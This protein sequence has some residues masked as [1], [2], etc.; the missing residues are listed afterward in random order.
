MQKHPLLC[1]GPGC[2]LCWLAENVGAY[3]QL[4]GLPITAPVNVNPEPV[5][6]PAHDIQPK[7]EIKIVRPPCS[8]LGDDT[9]RR[10]TC[11]TCKGNVQLKLFTC[12]VHGNCTRENAVQGITCCKNCPDYSSQADEGHDSAPEQP[13]TPET[14][15]RLEMLRLSQERED[16]PAH[17]EG[18]GIV[19]CAGGDKFFACAWAQISMLRWLGCNLP[20]E[21]FHLGIAEMDPRMKELL[22]GL[23]GVKVVDALGI[24]ASLPQKPRIL[25]GWELKPFSITHSSFAEVLFLD[26]DCYPGRDP[27]FLFDDPRY[28]GRGALF[29]PDLPPRKRK[30]WVPQVVW[31]NC[32]LPFDPGIKAFESGQ[33][34]IDK[35]RCWDELRVCRWMNEHSDYWYRQVYGDKDTFLLSWHAIAHSRGDF[36][37]PSYTIAPACGWRRPA[38]IQHDFNGEELFYHCCQGKEQIAGS[39]LRN[40]PLADK[41][42]DAGRVLA[43]QWQGSIW[44]YR[45][46]TDEEMRLS[47]GIPGRY[48]YEREGMGS[49]DL[50]LLPKGAIGTGRAAC[51]ERWTLRRPDGVLTL[52]I[53]GQA[54]KGTRVGIA[55]L[56]Q[57]GGVWR[58]RW[59]THERN[60][61]SLTPLVPQE[62]PQGWHCREGTW[63]RDIWDSVVRDNEYRLPPGFEPG[64]VV[65]DLGAH[66]G[67]FAL[68]CLVR[69]AARVVCVEPEGGNMTIAR[70][71]LASFG[72]RVDLREAACWPGGESVSVRHPAPGS[73]NT[74]QWQ[75]SA[76]GGTPSVD[77]NTLLGEIGP[78][79]FLKMD[80]EGSEWPVLESAGNL[81]GV[82]EV[83][84]EYHCREGRGPEQLR[85]LLQGKGFTVETVP[86]NEEQGHFFARR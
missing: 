63:D 70:R 73:P 6:N 4:W 41:V 86:A 35:R 81:D 14:W 54:H 60:G 32:C 29:W 55:F 20:V 40:L 61:C 51:E 10:V 7:E 46:Q 82:R 52:V 25:N 23:G 13:V 8:H 39:R 71:N 19:T 66:T 34:L 64:S 2:H 31:Q 57:A 80:I 45:D 30:A 75:C 27:S 28:L 11:P 72:A 44:D 24:V 58:G 36:F 78:V 62:P 50:E 53:T 37:R 9:G 18:R 59:T 33:M 69:G 15:H 47:L 16:P 5:Y 48:R 84:G 56:T 83:A 17:L 43:Q 74:G 38:I 12:D 77:L 79:R 68:A 3:Q 85:S 26:A 22:E 67:S 21:V 49:R 42:N 1:S 65:L 76:G